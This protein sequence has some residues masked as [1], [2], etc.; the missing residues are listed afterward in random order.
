M[1]KFINTSF[2]IGL[3]IWFLTAIY[4]SINSLIGIFVEL[5][6]TTAKFI[7]AISFVWTAGI[8]IFNK[9]RGGDFTH[10]SDDLQK[11]K[12]NLPRNE[13]GCKTCKKKK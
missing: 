11:V 9:I 8:G 4:L 10:L 5:N 7:L 1:K 6:P 2:V 3:I 12:E 13:V